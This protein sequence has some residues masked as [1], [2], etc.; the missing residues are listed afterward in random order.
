MLY[1]ASIRL[2]V[3]TGNEVQTFVRA[4]PSSHRPKCLLLHGNPATMLD[5]EPILP[6]LPRAWDVAAID[7]PGF[8]RSPRNSSDPESVCLDRLA[9][10]SIAVAD[11]LSWTEPFFVIGHSHGGGVAQV[12]AA[13]SPERVAG[14]VLI[15]TLSARKHG[16]YRFLELPFAEAVLRLAGYSLRSPALRPLGKSIMHRVM[17]GIWSPE[18]VPGERFERELALFSSRSEV[19][20]TMVHV[21]QGR[22]CEYLARSAPRIRCPVLL[23]HGERDALVPVDYAR[24][25]HELIVNA[26]GQSELRI[27]PG[28]GHAVLD[29]Q[30]TEVAHCITQFLSNC[31]LQKANGVEP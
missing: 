5:W 21:A 19:L 17:K 23:V 18:S 13:R 20:V 12:M 14:I 26:G 10:C 28:A 7:L 27:L 3:A 4:G 30:A 25:V 31:D 15:S 29:Y 2:S 24:G 6:L 9:D 11:A 22:P 8:G 1:D 16:S